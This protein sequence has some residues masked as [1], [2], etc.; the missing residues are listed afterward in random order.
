MKLPNKYIAIDIETTDAEADKGDVIQIGAIVLNENLSTGEEFSTY[1]APTSNHRN[2]RAM[3]ANKI[4]ESVLESAPNNQSALDR[5]EEFAFRVD[6]RPLLAAWGTYFDVTFL[7]AYYKKIGRKW[8]FSYRC[9]DLKTIAIWEQAKKEESAS[10][11]VETFLGLT[12]QSFDGTPHDAL[13]DIRNTI[14]IIQKL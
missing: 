3:D 8:P 12:G 10:G 6:A 5:F 14:K 7:K 2:P 9:L 11:G 4:P 1:I 13:D